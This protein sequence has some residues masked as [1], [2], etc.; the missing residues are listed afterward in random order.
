MVYERFRK[1]SYVIVL[2]F[3]IY[4]TLY[5][6][7]PI[8]DYLRE[9][10]ACLDILGNI[11]LAV[12][13]SFFVLMVF[14]L[15]AKGNIR[16]RTTHFLLICAALLYVSIIWN[17]EYAEEKI[18]FFE[19]GLLAWLIY[20][21]L[22]G[23]L[24][25]KSLFACSF[26]AVSIIGWGDEWIQYLLP[27][28]YYDIRDVIMNATGGLMGLIIALIMKADRSSLKTALKG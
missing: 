8:L 6:V 27:N 13:G 16:K 26:V 19:Y 3:F 5:I 9:N 11:L 23:D 21:A 17:I 20:R 1:W 25:G 18:H 28:R 15:K 14:V 10:I 12:V 22:D 2:V 4:S 7:R 24:K